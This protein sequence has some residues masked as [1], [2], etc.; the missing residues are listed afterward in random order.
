VI[1]AGTLIEIRD[2]QIGDEAAI[3][4][5]NRRAFGGDEECRIVD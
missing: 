1:G 2:E 5:V 3:R 4:E